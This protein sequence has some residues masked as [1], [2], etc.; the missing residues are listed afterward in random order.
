M[1]ADATAEQQ[2]ASNMGVFVNEI[3]QTHGGVPDEVHRHP[4]IDEPGMRGF[5]V[6]FR[7]NPHE[8][9]LPDSELPPDGVSDAVV[10]LDGEPIPWHDAV[11]RIRNRPAK[12]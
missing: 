7:G 10:L 5:R 6:N 4:L 8:V 11:S 12:S 1:S 3:A 9:L 2:A